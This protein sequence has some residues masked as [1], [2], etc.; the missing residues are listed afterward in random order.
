MCI[1]DDQCNIVTSELS[2]WIKNEWVCTWSSFWNFMLMATVT[3]LPQQCC[4]N[5]V[6]WDVQSCET[7]RVTYSLLLSSPSVLQSFSFLR[8][9]LLFQ[10]QMPLQMLTSLLRALCLPCQ[11]P[12]EHCTSYESQCS[13]EHRKKNG[14]SVK[15]NSSGVQAL[16]SY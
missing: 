11:P 1:Y 8:R 15:S 6:K 5:W 4:R 9:A 3:C 2:L 7:M 13:T 16:L 12:E 14:L 10:D